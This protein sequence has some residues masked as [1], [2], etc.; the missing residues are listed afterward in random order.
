MQQMGVP[1]S[2]IKVVKWIYVENSQRG[3]R[4]ETSFKITKRLLQY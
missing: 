1:Q 2:F 3:N 4:I